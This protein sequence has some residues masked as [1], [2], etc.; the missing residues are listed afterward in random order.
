MGLFSF[1][2]FQARFLVVYK[3]FQV[4][5][6]TKVVPRAHSAPEVLIRDISII[7]V[8]GDGTEKQ[9]HDAD[10]RERET[11]QRGIENRAFQ[12]TPTVRWTR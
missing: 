6:R 10:L 8:P 9:Y 5:D 4:W 12:R 2:Y 7:T 11:Q 3:D 1:I